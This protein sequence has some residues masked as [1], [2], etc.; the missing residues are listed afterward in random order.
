LPALYLILPGIERKS[1]VVT[2]SCQLLLSLLHRW[3][4]YWRKNV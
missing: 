2:S 4:Q 1:S 3:V